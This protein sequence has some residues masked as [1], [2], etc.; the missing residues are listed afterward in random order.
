ML[1]W[2][3][4]GGLTD[5]DYD[6]YYEKWQVFDPSGL[7]FIRYDQLSDF[8]D[9]LEAPLRV[10]KPN[11]LLFV[12]MNLPICE[13]DRMHCV[14]ILDAL[15]KNFLGKPDLLGENSLGGEPPIDIKK[16][17]PKDYHPVTTTLQRQREIYLSRLGLNGFRTNLQRSRNQQLLLEKSTISQTD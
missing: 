14:D 4:F 16:D 12:V 5:D 17:R 1:L 9:G 3:E 7:Q 8:V 2:F 6:M 10:S 11:K 15:T 13:N